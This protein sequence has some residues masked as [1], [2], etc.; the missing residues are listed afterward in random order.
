MD[1][2]EFGL[3][4]AQKLTG[5]EHLHFGFWK[6]GET[7]KI[8]AL[9]KAQ[10]QYARMLAD[11]IKK[12]TRGRTTP[13][14]LDV[15]PGSGTMI[16]R[17][18]EAGYV[19]DGVTPSKYLY[20]EM[21][22]RLKT[23]KKVSSARRDFLCRFEEL[24]QHKLRHKYDLVYCS[25]SFQ[26]LKLQEALPVLRQILTPGGKVVIC[27]FFKRNNKPVPGQMGGG[28][29]L[30]SFYK[31]VSAAGF[32]L[33]S[34]RDITENTSPTIDMLDHLVRQR[35]LP[36]L[37]VAD[38]FLKA[39]HRFFYSCLRFLFRKPLFKIK[40]KYLTGHR[41]GKAFAKFKSYRLIVLEQGPAAH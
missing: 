3:V 26:Y 11:I 21:K 27:D 1:S 29:L 15:G 39:R 14:L 36:S 16:R 38:L 6:K 24:P 40:E 4:F 17:L 8:S 41:T 33:V 37:E 28:H 18:T 2:K 13:R 30:A 12:H 22:D 32:R 19:V 35:L 5:I 34:D 31:K 20:A 9:F 10:E 23:L 25:E 7:P